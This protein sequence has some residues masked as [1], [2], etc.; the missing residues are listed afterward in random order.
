MTRD[1]LEEQHANTLSRLRSLYM[2]K[3]KRLQA[4]P[5][6]Q[7]EQHLADGWVFAGGVDGEAVMRMYRTLGPYEHDV[8][9]LLMWLRALNAWGTAYPEEHLKATLEDIKRQAGYKLIPEL[10]GR[11]IPPSDGD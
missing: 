6:F 5:G 1:E 2:K 4:V 3:G 10:N 9:P 8:N 11:I 7:W